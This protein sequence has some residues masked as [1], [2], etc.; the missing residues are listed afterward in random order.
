MTWFAL[1]ALP[2]LC[3]VLMYG[4]YNFATKTNKY[5]CNEPVAFKSQIPWDYNTRLVVQPKVFFSSSAYKK[6]AQFINSILRQQILEYQDLKKHTHLWLQPPQ[7]SRA[8]SRTQEIR[9]FHLFILEIQPNLDYRNQNAAPIFNHAHPKLFKT[10][11]YWHAKSQ[12]I[13][14]LCS[15]YVVWL[16][17]PVIWLTRSILANISGYWLFFDMGFVQVYSN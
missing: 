17:N 4:K 11:L 12:A 16:E 8:S 14:L 7:L 9:L 5:M 10:F 13:S 1:Y 3:S 2:L 15:K 6:W